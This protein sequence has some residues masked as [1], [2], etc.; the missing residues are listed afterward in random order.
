MIDE[1]DYFANLFEVSLYLQ[2]QLEFLAFLFGLDEFKLL[3]FGFLGFD[4]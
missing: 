3:D 4:V 1:V 2:I